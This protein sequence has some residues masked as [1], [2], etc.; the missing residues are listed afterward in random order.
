MWFKYSGVGCVA[1]LLLVDLVSGCKP[2][3]QNVSS[4]F[5]AYQATYPFKKRYSTCAEAGGGVGGFGSPRSAGFRKH[6]GCDVYAPWRE[7][8]YAVE[9]GVVA[10]GEYGFYCNTNAIEINH[11]GRIVRYGEIS[12]GSAQGFGLRPGTQVKKGQAIARV[13]RLS[14]YSIPMLHFEMYS[15]TASGGLTNFASLPYNRR[16]D[17]INPTEF[18]MSSRSSR[19]AGTTVATSG[20]DGGDDAGSSGSETRSD[21]T[22]AKADATICSTGKAPVYTEEGEDI[23]SANPGEPVCL[24]FKRNAKGHE[25]VYFP[26]PPAGY[27]W[28]EN[29]DT[30]K[31]ICRKAIAPGSVQSQSQSPS[32]VS[33]A[34]S[35]SASTASL[36]ICADDDV[37]V[38]SSTGAKIGVA[39]PGEPVCSLNVKDGAGRL[40]LYFPLPPVGAAYIAN[41]ERN[42]CNK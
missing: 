35:C 26:R 39:K 20:E 36:R 38:Y 8:I 33:S 4:S 6:A 22:E 2:T 12:P 41:P 28:V 31:N 14:C 7:V 16:S 5:N 13:G 23:G 34:S 1:A 29:T 42:V 40:K 3:A 11:D 19:L 18:L 27:G 32:S 9:D 30:A 15:G 10:E 37:P 24:Q 21:C 17:I 25:K